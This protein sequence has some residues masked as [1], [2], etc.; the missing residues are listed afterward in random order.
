[1][2][3][4]GITRNIVAIVAEHASGRKVTRVT[5]DIGRLSGVMSDAVRFCFDVVARGTCVEGAKLHI[6]DIEGRGRCRACHAEF[7]TPQLYSPCTCGNRDIERLAGEELKVREFEFEIES[8]TGWS[9][10][11]GATAVQ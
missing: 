1:M 7:A 5:V 4:L 9:Y 11:S 8:P 3:E 10:Q 6:R 2:H